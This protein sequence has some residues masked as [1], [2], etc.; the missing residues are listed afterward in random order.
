MNTQKHI[1][2]VEA[3]LALLDSLK[4]VKASTYFE[5]RQLA[6]LEAKL[7]VKN[8]LFNWQTILKPAFFIIFLIGINITIIYSYLHRVSVYSNTRNTTLITLSD[9]YMRSNDYYSLTNN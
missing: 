7:L 1:Q 3:C 5:T 2:K 6:Y 9:N 8:S 4:K